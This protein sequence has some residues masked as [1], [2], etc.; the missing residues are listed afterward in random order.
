MDLTL[1]RY[2]KDG[3]RTLGELHINGS[4]FCDTLEPPTR[5]KYSCIPNSIYRVENYPSERF[6]RMMPIVIGE[7][8]RRGILIHRGNTE[9]DTKGC[10]LVG[11]REGVKLKDSAA[12]FSE[13]YNRLALAWKRGEVVYLCICEHIVQ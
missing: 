3:H 8:R 4:F 2:S 13:L 10:I 12:M 9:H 6:K 5:D 1:I 11:T 7:H